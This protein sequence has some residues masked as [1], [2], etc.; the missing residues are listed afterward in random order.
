MEE[1]IPEVVERCLLSVSEAM[2]L[3]QIPPMLLCTLPLHY[4]NGS[5]ALTAFILRGLVPYDALARREFCQWIVLQSA[6]H[7]TF[8]VN[9]PFTYERSFTGTEI[10]SNN[11]EHLWPHE[12]LMGFHVTIKNNSFPLPVGCNHW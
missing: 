5:C 12:V 9:I 7:P 2:Q 11:N 4:N 3:L 8:K 6:E 1:L 10:T